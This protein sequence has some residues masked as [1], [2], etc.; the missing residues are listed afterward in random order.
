MSYTPHTWVDNETITAAKLNNIEDGVQEAAQSGGGYDAEIKIYHSNNSADDYELTILS[1]SYA[2]LRALLSN[3]VAPVV[4]VR[5]YDAMNYYVGATTNVYFYNDGTG[6]SNMIL[7]VKASRQTTGT[8][9]YDWWVMNYLVWSTED[10][11]FID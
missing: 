11:L 2:S 8:F 5:V 9:S 4:L 6:N 1:G 3:N 10:E 7:F